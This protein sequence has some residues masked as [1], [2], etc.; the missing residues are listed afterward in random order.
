MQTPILFGADYSVYTRIA[1]L[2]LIEKHVEHQFEAVD[3]FNPAGPSAEHLKR[4]PFGKI[5]ALSHGDFTLFETSAIARYVDEEFDGPQLQPA[6]AQGRA[7]VAQIVG[8]LDAYGYRSMVWDIF[9]ERVRKPVRGE[10]SDEARIAAGVERAGLCL[11]L[12]EEFMGDG[13][14]LVGDSKNP[15]LADPPE[16]ATLLERRPGVA[17][18]WDRIRRRSSMRATPSPMFRD[19]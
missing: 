13:L 18:W 5:P 19:S 10:A 2:A 11:R 3:I 12:L 14:W 7:R 8:L 4:Q 15:S 1:R 17:A 16:G 6:R 9:V